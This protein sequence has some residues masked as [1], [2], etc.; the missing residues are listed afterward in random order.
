MRQKILIADDEMRHRNQMS[1]FLEKEG[2]SVLTAGNGKAAIEMFFSEEDI[3]LVILDLMM[4][5]IDGMEVCRVIRRQSDVPI[6]F[7]T[8]LGD[9]GSEIAGLAIGADDCISKPLSYGLLSARIHAVLRRTYPEKESKFTYKALEVDLS[10]S[11]VFINEEKVDL[12]PRE[13]QLLKCL[14]QNKNIA[15]NRHQILDS[16]WGYDY[17][18]DTRTVDTHIKSLRSKLGVYAERIKTIRGLGYK[19]ELK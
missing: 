3:G 15:L 10:A 4:P 18:G 9:V 12:S 5:K 7:L 11:L 14:V 2:Y 19:I 8:A 1:D 13:F 6:I 17:F 16:A